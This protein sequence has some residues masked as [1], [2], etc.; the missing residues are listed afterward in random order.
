MKLEDIEK[1][2]YKLDNNQNTELDLKDKKEVISEVVQ[3]NQGQSF[4]NEKERLNNINNIDIKEEKIKKE[5]PR[6][7]F[8]KIIISFSLLIIIGG[9]SY[10]Y[11]FLKIKPLE[12]LNVDLIMPENIFLGVPS[13]FEISITNPS[14][15]LIKDAKLI[16]ILPSGVFSLN[17]EDQI[18]FELGDIKQNEIIK[19]DFSLLILNEELKTT[20]KIKTILD[21]SLGGRQRFQFFKEFSFFPYLEPIEIT[22]KK[23][24][25]IFLGDEFEFLINLNN[26]TD[27]NYKQLYLE[28]ILPKNYELIDYGELEKV[29]QNIFLLK[30][31]K[32][33]EK[34]NL[35]FLGKI[36][37]K[38]TTTS[39]FNFGI[40][41]KNKIEGEELILAK[42]GFTLNLAKDEID[43]NI[44]VN[45]KSNYLAKD[46][47]L[48]KY[49]ISIKNNSPK[50]ISDIILKVKFLND[51]FDFASLQGNFNFDEKE[52][53]IIW[54]PNNN[55]SL[56]NLL[57]DSETNFIFTVKLKKM[58]SELSD[59]KNIK[60][61]IE[62]I[63]D[64]PTIIN[65]KTDKTLVKKDF[66]T[67]I[68]GSLSGEQFLYY[69]LKEEDG[70]GP[71]PLKVNEKTLVKLIWQVKTQLTDFNNVKLK[72]YLKD[73]VEL[74]EIIFSGEKKP[75]YNSRTKEILW[76]IDKI[77]ANSQLEAI[78]KL[79][80]TPN[81]KMLNKFMP[82][83]SDLSFEGIDNFT[84]EKIISSFKA[85]DSSLIED[86]KENQ[87]LLKVVE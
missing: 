3:S 25:Y 17:K 42:K 30:D 62:V 55:L 19:K 24:D 39:V 9:L 2:I 73:N 79:E 11:F 48:L 74:K 72:A 82:I 47:D 28:L 49:K 38:E 6:N 5:K 65:P 43:I 87:T 51:V 59:I 10:F 20:K 34:R 18:R 15:N 31:Y 29:K 33:F 37:K 57:S 35:K 41:L 26:S 44:T 8:F 64:S 32:S 21:Y 78:F 56:R 36:D 52:K 23:P 63:L 7:Y 50:S 76:Q 67:K 84:K 46:G 75:I 54:L 77:N 58:F 53:A 69:S 14:Q 16:I 80:L 68:K 83:I 27:Y 13:N 70:E 45:D 85:L 60:A 61:L 86:L 22:F 71:I 4:F 40:V 12:N 81:I 66:E 1:K